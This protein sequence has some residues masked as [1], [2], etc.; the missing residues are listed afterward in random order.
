MLLDQ[1]L[2]L[3]TDHLRV[4]NQMGYL[5]PQISVVVVV[6]GKWLYE[7]PPQ[8]ISPKPLKAHLSTSDPMH[9]IFHAGKP[10]TCTISPLKVNGL[11]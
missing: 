8:G 3:G 9:C 7:P 11:Q 4:A 10:F 5:Q 2:T 6:V 1:C